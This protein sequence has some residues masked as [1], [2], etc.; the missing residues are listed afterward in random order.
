MWFH[1]IVSPLY[2]GH[3]TKKAPQKQTTLQF[4]PLD[5]KKRNPWSDSES[6]SGS[7][8]EV[9]DLPPRDKPQRTT[10]RVLKFAL[11]PDISNWGAGNI[12]KD[13]HWR[14]LMTGHVLNVMDCFN[15]SAKWKDN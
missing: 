13:L 5:K 10:G 9:V 14:I 11:V 7:D 1:W 6:E 12:L 2:L 4:K 15:R 8:V 3:K